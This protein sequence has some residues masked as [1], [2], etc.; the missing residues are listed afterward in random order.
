MHVEQFLATRL[1]IHPTAFVAENCTLRGEVT[2]G[3]DA[4]L[5]FQSV[6]RGDT[7]PIRI[8][9]RSNIQDGCIL[10]TDLDLPVEIGDDVTVGH[11][12]IVHGAKVEGEVL[13]AMRATILSGAVIGRRCIIG[14]GALVPEKAVIPSGSLVLG[15]P[16]RIV[17]PLSE[18]EVQR[19]LENARVY[20]DY[21]R[22][23]REGRVGR[24]N[25]EVS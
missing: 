14:A 24:P 1:S 8:G 9:E 19:I 5:W 16:G 4:S 10:H 13:V 2:V 7:A 17:R 25:R 20:L 18:L 6:L 23:Y 11:G 15:V 21:A 22:A 12:A 3:A